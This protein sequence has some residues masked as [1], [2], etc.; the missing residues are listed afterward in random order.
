MINEHHTH[1]DLVAPYKQNNHTH[2]L[3]AMHLSC[4]TIIRTSLG[5][6]NTETKI[7]KHTRDTMARVIRA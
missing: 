1:I 4:H 5:S 3:A 7:N 2:I 6:Q